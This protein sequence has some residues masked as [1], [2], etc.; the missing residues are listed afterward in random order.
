MQQKMLGCIWP[1]IRTISL[2]T[3]PAVSRSEWVEIPSKEFPK[4]RES[5]SHMCECTSDFSEALKAGASG[6]IYR[7]GTHVPSK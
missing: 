6:S 2:V 4:L 1:R 5:D 7:Q 3:K